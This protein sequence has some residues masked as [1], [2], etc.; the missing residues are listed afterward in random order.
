MIDQLCQTTILGVGVVN[1]FLY[2]RPEANIRKYA[3]ILG[4]I[5]QP[6]WF[7]TSYMKQQWGVFFLSFWFTAMGIKGI[8]LH[9]IKPKFE[10]VPV[11]EI[12]LKRI[13]KLIN[14]TEIS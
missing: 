1:A 10:V 6:A 5:N 3:Y 8:Y 14:D 9:W 2:A 11:D 4:L 12:Q 7:Y 13:E